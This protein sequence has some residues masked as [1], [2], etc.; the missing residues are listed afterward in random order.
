[1]KINE[2][3]IP[4]KLIK[5]WENSAP[6]SD[7][8]SQNITLSSDDYDYLIFVW[9]SYKGRN[10]VCSTFVPKGYG[11]YLNLASDYSPGG[12]AGYYASTYIR[13]ATRN[14]DT[15][16]TIGNCYV[17]Y[18]N[19]TTRPTASTNIIPLVIYGGKF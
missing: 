10:E 12:G 18:G 9:D 6:T 4:P 3:L 15:S 14:S 1:M 19:Q 11:G 17:R 5:L 16:F 7:F 8:S 2:K 13:E